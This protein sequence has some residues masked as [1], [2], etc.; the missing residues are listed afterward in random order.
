MTPE[1]GSLNELKKSFENY[2]M[3]LAQSATRCA[4]T[5]AA[6]ADW[7]RQ[8]QAVLR[9]LTR[10]LSQTDERALV[11][12]FADVKRQ[13]ASEH[14]SPDEFFAEMVRLVELRNGLPKTGGEVW[15]ALKDSIAS[16]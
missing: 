14:V 13:I 12:F 5:H 9:D 4:R 16:F 15:R 7:M 8:A 1:V 6:R 3:M 11:G 2:R 10:D